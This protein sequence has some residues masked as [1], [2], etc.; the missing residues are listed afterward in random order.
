VVVLVHCDVMVLVLVGV[1]VVTV[2]VGVLVGVAV[3]TVVVLV[4]VGMFV[5]TMMMGVLVG[6]AV[7]AMVV[8]M[9][10]GVAVLALA[11]GAVAAESQD[12]LG[13]EYAGSQGGGQNQV[14]AIGASVVSTHCASPRGILLVNTVCINILTE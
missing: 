10:V 2:V 6:V 4:L 12:T 13:S 3:V 8:L 1:A 11:F 9:L 5:V 14:L 7:T